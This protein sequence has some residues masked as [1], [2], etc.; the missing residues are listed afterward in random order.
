M[1]FQALAQ[2]TNE[3]GVVVCPFTNDIWKDPKIEKV[4]VM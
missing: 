2:I 4:Y 3:N 1:I